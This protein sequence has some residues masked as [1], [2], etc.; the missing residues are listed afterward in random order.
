MMGDEISHNNPYTHNTPQRE[1]RRIQNKLNQR[2]RRKRLKLA[3]AGSCK[4]K[5]VFT[6]FFWICVNL[7]WLVVEE[8]VPNGHQ[9]I[10]HNTLQP[11]NTYQLRGRNVLPKCGQPP[12]SQKRDCE[13]IKVACEGSVDKSQMVEMEST[14]EEGIRISAPSALAAGSKRPC[15]PSK[16]LQQTEGQHIGDRLGQSLQT[17]NYTPQQSDINTVRSVSKAPRQRRI[18]SDEQ[19]SGQPM[20]MTTT[21]ATVETCIGNRIVDVARGALDHVLSISPDSQ[22]GGDSQTICIPARPQMHTHM[23]A[24]TQDLNATLAQFR[25]SFQQVFEF[26]QAPLNNLQDRA[27]GLE[28][29]LYRRQS[30]TMRLG[31]YAAWMMIDIENIIEAIAGIEVDSAVIETLI[32]EISKAAQ[33][34]AKEKVR[35]HTRVK[36]LEKNLKVLQ[37][38]VLNM[39]SPC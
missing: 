22:N 25:A 29:E 27:T 23:P 4:K 2:R 35:L 33:K 18:P 28:Q 13:Y 17:T 30:E 19:E 8:P 38:I 26:V 34:R 31:R 9:H 10:T 37:N 5:A 24:P 7:I 15:Y 39:A 1:R 11:K 16:D 32:V 6:F 21:P 3:A 36:G 12:L 20:L 14:S